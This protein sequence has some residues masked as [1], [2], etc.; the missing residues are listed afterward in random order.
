MLSFFRL[1]LIG[2]L[3]GIADLIPGISGGTVAFLS[4]IYDELLAA[5]GSLQIRSLKSVHWK[6]LFS[7][8]SGIVTAF[9][10]FAHII[11]YLLT[12]AVY[13]FYFMGFFLGLLL[14]SI[15]LFWRKNPIK[16]FLNIC[17]LLIGIF[18]SAFLCSQTIHPE[19][20]IHLGWLILFGCLASG[21]MLLPGISGSYVLNLVGVYPLIIL[22][23]TNLKEGFSILYPLMIG[24]CFGLV[25]FSRLIHFLL[26]RFRHLMFALLIGLMIGGLRGVVHFSVETRMISFF[27]MGLGFTTLLII[28]VAVSQSQRRLNL[29]KKQ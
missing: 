29:I 7:L 2:I 6:F 25:I 21:A 17:G 5:I 27:F 13:S 26:R 12:H 8:G 28:E 15:V 3:F 24:I 1:Y 11:Q 9:L 19:P 18:I 10:G 16:G 4:G 14:G 22:A 23:L 20:N